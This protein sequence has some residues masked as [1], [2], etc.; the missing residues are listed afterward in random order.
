MANNSD[1][2]FFIQILKYWE[3]IGT[4]ILIIYQ[5]V[6]VPQGISERKIT[7]RTVVSDTA[8]IFDPFG[9]LLPV[10]IRGR[11]CTQFVER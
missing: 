8:K 2:S 11:L 10:T 6:Y 9:W 4:H 5:L 1:I 3:L 7:K